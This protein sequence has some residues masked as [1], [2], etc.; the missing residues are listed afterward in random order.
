MSREDE[1][2]ERVEKATKGPWSTRFIY[3]LFSAARKNPAI[4]V[5]NPEDK[6]WDNAEFIAHAIT[7]IPYLLEEL[8][9]VR[10]EVERL[11]RQ[12]DV[13]REWIKEQMPR[14][15]TAEHFSKDGMFDSPRERRE[16]AASRIDAME[17]P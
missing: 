3:R 8:R 14:C 12:R 7:D 5:E 13:L 17:R 4:L 6:D 10:E 9:K 11:T 16:E 2:R 15:L 1:I